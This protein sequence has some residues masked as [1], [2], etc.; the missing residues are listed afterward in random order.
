MTDRWCLATGAVVA[1]ILAAYCVSAT[2][3]YDDDTITRFMMVREATRSPVYLLDPWARPMGI[4]PF[5]PVAWIGED[6]QTGFVAVKVVNALFS[7]LAALFACGAARALEWPR[8]WAAAVMVGLQP[9]FVSLSYS[10]CPETVFALLLSL[11]LYLWSSSLTTWALLVASLLPLARWEYFPLSIVLAVLLAAKGRRTGAVIL[12]GPFVLWY[13]LYAVTSG[14]PAWIVHYA[15]RG[16]SFYAEVK[17]DYLHYLRRFPEVF[18][19]PVTALIL[20]RTFFKVDKLTALAAWILLTQ[21]ALHGHFGS[22]GLSRHLVSMSPVAGLLAVD[23]M[24]R[25]L[26]FFGPRAGRIAA[27]VLVVLVSV[28]CLVTTRPIALD[29]ERILVGD[30]ARKY[31]SVT[32]QGD[33]APV[34]ASHVWIDFYLGASPFGRPLMTTENLDLSPSGTTVFWDSHY[35][36]RLAYKVPLDYFEKNSRYELLEQAATEDRRFALFVFRKR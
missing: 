34:M 28:W 24:N 2:G 5:L 15:Q 36:A 21:I 26:A 27:G 22:I 4:I 11:S 13:I 31:R 25:I 3:T 17:P 12:L 16:G 6:Y 9:L 10:M 30:V 20:V 33:Q 23:G 19:W 8:A 35:S 29:E 7:F 18:G 32:A 1:L 14:D